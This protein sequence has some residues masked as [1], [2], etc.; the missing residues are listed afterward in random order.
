MRKDYINTDS[1]DEHETMFVENYWTR[2]WEREGGPKGAIERIPS[3]DEYRLMRPYLNLGGRI[4]DGGCGLGDWVLMF[5]KEGFEVTGMDLSR[6]T[7]EQ[8]RTLFPY[9]KFICGDIRHTKYPDNYF[10]AYYSWGVFEHFEAGP[11]D[12]I[13]E[14]LRILKPGG[15]LFISV[16]LDNL[17]QSL[18]GTFTGAKSVAAGARFY[19]Y[20]FTR[21]ELAREL[22]LGGFELV[23]F[24]PIH[25]RQGVLRSLHHEFGLPYQWLLTRGLSVVLAPFIPRWWIAHMMLAVAKKPGA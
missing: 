2:V 6:H 1:P 12:C 4:F 5:D 23:S 15:S 21:E 20:R 11:R 8:L 25:R 24:H 16:P 3:L 10:D 13:L 17:R 18:L 9:A 19:Q 22:S 14:A 7:V